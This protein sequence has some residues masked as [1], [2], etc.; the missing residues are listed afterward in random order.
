MV[1]GAGGECEASW[2]GEDSALEA[3]AGGDLAASVKSEASF[4][5]R[6]LWRYGLCS[7]P[8][9]ADAAATCS[10]QDEDE[11]KIA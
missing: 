10:L 4:V 11:E 9:A 3:L 1:G 2:S 7:E 5:L 8:S 6:N